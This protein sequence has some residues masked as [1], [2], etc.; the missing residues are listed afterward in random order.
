MSAIDDI[1]DKLPLDQLAA[2]LG[3]DP[4]SVR[5]ASGDAI[6][7]LLGGLQRNSSEPI[8]Q[9][10]LATALKDHSASQLLRSDDK[11][12]LN[13][14]DQTDGAKIVQH[15][16]GTDPARAVQ[17]SGG[18]GD[19]GLIQR[20]LPIIAP[21]VLA[22]LASRLGDHQIE[23]GRQGEGNGG[24]ILEAILGRSGQLGANPSA[25]YQRGYQDGYNAARQ[26]GQ[27]QGGL[28][29]GDLIGGM[30]GGDQP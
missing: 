1:L 15:A 10:S 14:I 27:Q 3:S 8:G 9:N 6:A 22:Y 7:S 23:A 18:R 29:L 12:D 16:L 13:Q 30:M 20:L 25:D 5:M 28:S 19:Q 11:I 17:A 2:Q 21:M 26:E 4:R 24:S